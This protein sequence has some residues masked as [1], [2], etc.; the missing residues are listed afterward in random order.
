MATK[1]GKKYLEAAK[2]VDRS[3]TYQ[4]DEAI[5]LVKQTSP[6]KFDATV[7]THLRAGDR[8]PPRRSAGARHRRP[9]HGTGRSVRVVVFAQGD[10]PARPRRPG[11][12]ASA[13]TT[14]S[15]DIQD[16]WLE[17]DVAVATPDIMGQVGR[18]GRILGPRG[19]MP[20]P[21]RHRHARHRAR[22]PE[23]KAGRVEF[24]A[25]K[26]ACSTSPS[27][28]SPSRRPAD[29]EPAVAGRRG[30]RAQPS[31]AK[32]QYVRSITLTTTMGPGIRLDLPG[33]W[34]PRRRSRSTI[35]SPAQAGF[36]VQETDKPQ[37]AC[38]PSTPPVP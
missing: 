36:M 5:A 34:R 29:R 6:T 27:A 22:V 26:G 24:R 23:V 38:A 14:W 1:H 19:L 20:N 12:T 10:R 15:Q 4:P 3:R 2:L 30:L 18:L 8:P 16:G 31:G 35:R 25:D 37:T 33:G 13:P 32:G 21:H 11:P 7:E 17:F 28:R 9:P